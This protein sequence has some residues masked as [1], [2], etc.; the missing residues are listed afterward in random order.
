M[1][2]HALPTA[3]TPPG[4]PPP[5]WWC[6]HAETLTPIHIK[7]NKD[8]SLTLSVVAPPP[9]FSAVYETHPGPFEPGILRSALLPELHILIPEAT[10]GRIRNVPFATAR[11]NLPEY[12]IVWDVAGRHPSVIRTADPFVIIPA[13]P[14]NDKL[15]AGAIPYARTST[16]HSVEGWAYFWEDAQRAWDDLI[17]PFYPSP[18]PAK[19]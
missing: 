5:P 14:E 3:T 19:K 18:P 17:Q 16:D 7:T 2:Y 9:D 4:T 15:L 1:F 13:T 12:L 6:F 11:P 8:R 10:I